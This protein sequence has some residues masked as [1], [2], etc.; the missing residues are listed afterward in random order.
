MFVVYH[1]NTIGSIWYQKN[2]HLLGFV[3]QNSVCENFLFVVVI[4]WNHKFIFTPRMMESEPEWDE[5]Q[6]NNYHNIDLLQLWLQQQPQLL[7]QQPPQ[8]LQQPTTTTPATTSNLTSTTTNFIASLFDCLWC[9]PSLPNNFTCWPNF[10]LICA[11]NVTNFP[12]IVKSL[13]SC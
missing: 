9:K 4:D 5:N 7:Q 8:L 13:W 12:P 2:F 10:P 3:R 11:S 6:N 1:H